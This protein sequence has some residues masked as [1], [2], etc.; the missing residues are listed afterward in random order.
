MLESFQHIVRYYQNICIGKV[1]LPI[2]PYFP[3]TA[4]IPYIQFEPICC[5]GF[6]VKSRGGRHLRSIGTTIRK[7]KTHL[8]QNTHRCYILGSQLFENRCLAGIV[9]AE[10]QN[11][12]LLFR[13]GAQFAQ[14]R[15]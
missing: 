15:K 10:Q 13:I 12:C 6:D 1:V 4:N 5:Y 9:Q 14:Q 8:F 2:G 11:A 7:A 3:L